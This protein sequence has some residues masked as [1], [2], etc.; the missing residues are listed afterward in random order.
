MWISG[1][2]SPKQQSVD[3]NTLSRKQ[4]P[5]ISLEEK[6]NRKCKRC[7]L[8]ANLRCVSLFVNFHNSDIISLAAERRNRRGVCVCV[9]ADTIMHIKRFVYSSLR[10]LTVSV[11]VCV[12]ADLC[13]VCI[14]SLCV[15]PRG[16][17]SLPW[18][19]L[20][21]METALSTTANGD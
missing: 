15:A 6:Q 3:K 7:R 13:G 8:G 4:L 21:E 11:C 16:V 10:I 20:E 9:S 5:D 14:V 18:P 19:Q 1:I 12:C 2:S 17:P